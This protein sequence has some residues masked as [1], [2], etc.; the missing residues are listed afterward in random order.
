[1]C[2]VKGMAEAIVWSKV[3]N[4]K[5]YI[6]LVLDHGREEGQEENRRGLMR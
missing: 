3:N 5:Y 2:T 4:R 6:D 1:M